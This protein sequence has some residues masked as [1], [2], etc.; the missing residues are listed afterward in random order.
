MGLFSRL[1]VTCMPLV[2]KP[3]VG[4]VAKRYVAGVT[5]DACVETVKKLNAEGAMATID[6]LGEAVPNLEKPLEYV[7]QYDQVFEAIEAEQLDANVSTKPTML[8]LNLDEQ[9]C[10][11]HY[12]HLYE[13]AQQHNNWIRID[14]EDHP[15]TDVTLKIYRLMLEKYGNAG[16][17]LQAYMFRSLK[18]IGELPEGANIRLCKGIY[19]EPR[20]IAW[21]DYQIVRENFVAC[22]DKLFRQGC[23]V[24]IATHD[25]YLVHAG[26]ALVDKYGLKPEQYE[27]QMLLGV[28]PKLR[29]MIIDQGHRLRVYV[30]FGKDWYPYSTRRLRENPDMANHIIRAFFG[31]S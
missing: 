3:I 1:V 12:E 9:V 13:K 29:K 18:D 10:I 25:D 11:S 20:E 22:L 27:F 19:I 26:M 23:Y 8:A 30:P 7:E 24:G 5:L 4:F 6:V 21:R 2:P 15:Y 17:V 31:L 16:T 14:M 28:K